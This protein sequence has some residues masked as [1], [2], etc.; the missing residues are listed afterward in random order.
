M[1]RLPAP[2]QPFQDELLSSWVQRLSCAYHLRVREFL[3]WLG[4][5]GEDT[6]QIDLDLAPPAEFVSRLAHATGLC[7]ERIHQHRA[8][9]PETT[10]EKHQRIAFCPFCWDEDIDDGTAPYVRREWIDAWCVHCRRHGCFLQSAGSEVNLFNLPFMECV[11]SSDIDWAHSA[12]LRFDRRFIQHYSDT[13]TDFRSKLR[14]HLIAPTRVELSYGTSRFTSWDNVL[15]WFDY[16][17]QLRKNRAGQANHLGVSTPL[18]V[19]ADLIFFS[20]VRFGCGESLLSSA[21]PVCRVM[22]EPFQSTWSRSKRMEPRGSI[23][24]RAGAFVMARALWTLLCGFEAPRGSA[25]R[26][27]RQFPL[28]QNKPEADWIARRVSHW[29][30][31]WRANWDALNSGERL[32]EYVG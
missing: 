21:D 17:W 12:N 5:V 28:A 32:K 29:P 30:Q 20:L 8:I 15:F 18:S 4:G 6:D 19:V 24:L 7:A 16:C 1:P 27:C 25:I 11:W 23:Q 26:I 3:A 2:V 31:N 22:G 13:Y 14:M 10:L 9:S